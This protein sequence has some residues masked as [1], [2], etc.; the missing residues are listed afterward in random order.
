MEPPV[1]QGFQVLGVGRSTTR[2]PTSP[3]NGTG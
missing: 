1:L 2:L 3:K